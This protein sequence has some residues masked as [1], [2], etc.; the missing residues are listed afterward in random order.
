MIRYFLV[1]ISTNLFNCVP[2]CKQVAEKAP[3]SFQRIL[4]NLVEETVTNSCWWKIPSVAVVSWVVVELLGFDFRP[5]SGSQDM[6]TFSVPMATAAADCSWHQ[7]H[8]AVF[9]SAS[10]VGNQVMSSACLSVCLLWLFSLLSNLS[11]YL[12]SFCSLSQPA[13]PTI[14]PPTHQPVSLSSCLSVS[15]VCLSVS[16]PICY[17]I[18]LFAISLSWLRQWGSLCLTVCLSICQTFHLISQSVCLSVCQSLH[19]SVFLS[20]RSVWSIYQWT[21]QTVWQ[22][23]L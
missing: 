20:V 16:E 12:S 19:Q 17:L 3:L 13:S 5:L 18:C 7:A 8:Q 10:L 11:V 22:F 9:L 14:H 21:L 15:S 1:P 6:C 4:Q 23:P 2:R